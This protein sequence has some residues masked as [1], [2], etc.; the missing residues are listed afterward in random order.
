MAVRIAE[1]QYSQS[2]TKAEN[3]RAMG[4]AHN[5]R[6]RDNGLGDVERSRQYAATQATVAYESALAAAQKQH[7]VAT[8]GRHETL[9]LDELQDT[10]NTN[11]DAADNRGSSD[12]EFARTTAA[13]DAKYA[14]REAVIA[15]SEALAR[16][17]AQIEQAYYGQERGYPARVRRKHCGGG[18]RSAS[19]ARRR[20]TLPTG[21]RMPL[22]GVPLR[23]PRRPPTWPAGRLRRIT[24]S[25]RTRF[26][27][28]ASTHGRQ[29]YSLTRQEQGKRR[30]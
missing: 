19:P 26:S 29:N 24:A 14:W 8:A 1:V 30:G 16:T 4:T 22:P 17:Q 3:D 18:I 11:S 28:V 25:R 20:S 21:M 7:A 12:I 27:T 13:Q 9:A 10:T 15:A 2:L 23:M 5:E 6:T